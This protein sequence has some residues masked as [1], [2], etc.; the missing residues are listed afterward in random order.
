VTTTEPH[1][2]HERPK[3][4]ASRR[5]SPEGIKESGEATFPCESLFEQVRSAGIHRNV[6]RILSDRIDLKGKF[7]IDLA[8][9]DGRTTYLLRGLG[10]KVKPYDLFPE[11]YKLDDHAESVD[12]QS[13]T[14]IPDAAADMIVFQEVMEHL[15]NQLFALQEMFRILKPGGEVFVTTPSRSSLASKLSYLCFES[16]TMKLPPWGPLESVWLHDA[17]SDRKCY[18]H[19]WLI[20]IQQLRTLA[21]LAGFKSIEIKRSEVS[22]SSLF[23]MIPFYP[24]VL[25]ISLRAL[26]RG[27]RGAATAVRRE[28]LEQFKLNVNPINLTNKFL[29]AVLRK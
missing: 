20:G 18:G 6:E 17:H 28:R 23:L 26:L 11:G 13:R 16:E 12:I 21:L 15:P 8:C 10:A 7:V 22:R 27:Y 4:A 9:G 14:A 3:A 1:V 24:L 2:T 19:V 29:I 5:P 25:L